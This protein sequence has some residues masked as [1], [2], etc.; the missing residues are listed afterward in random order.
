ML[1]LATKIKYNEDIS[2]NEKNFGGTLA[3]MFKGHFKVNL[4]QHAK[5]PKIY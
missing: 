5:Y 2:L 1:E 3:A 4:G